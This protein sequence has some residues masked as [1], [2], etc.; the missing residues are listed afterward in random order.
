MK[1]SNDVDNTP[2]SYHIENELG[3]DQLEG[4]A[5]RTR[6]YSHGDV[7]AE[8]LSLPLAIPEKKTSKKN[9][10]QELTESEADTLKD[11]PSLI[12]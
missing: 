6:S 5:K 4:D 1:E 7:E 10:V 9:S 3:G 12:A 2:G 8:G 11:D